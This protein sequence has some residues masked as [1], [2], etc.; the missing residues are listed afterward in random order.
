[1]LIFDY[2]LRGSLEYHAGSWILRF[3]ALKYKLW[4][5]EFSRFISLKYT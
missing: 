2:K 1:M 3:I 5:I 4:S